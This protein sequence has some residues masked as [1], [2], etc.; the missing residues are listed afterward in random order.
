MSD[1]P[2]GVAATDP[3]SRQRPSTAP[4]QLP[5]FAR[6]I[7]DV[8]ILKLQ[9]ES[10]FPELLEPRRRIDRALWAAIMTAYVTGTSTRKVDDLVKALGCDSGVSKSTVSRYDRDLFSYGDTST[11]VAVGPG[12]CD[13][14]LVHGAPLLARVDSP[15]PGAIEPR[16][17]AAVATFVRVHG[18]DDRRTPAVGSVE[19]T[20]APQSPKVAVVDA[21]PPQRE[22]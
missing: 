9:T 5:H 20:A 13:E 2:W 15:P 11:T 16:I 7:R 18:V 1:D 21:C 17:E 3:L 12:H 14:W 19:W 6:R 22:A 10:F 8:A 4:N